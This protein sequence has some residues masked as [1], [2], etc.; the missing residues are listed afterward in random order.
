MTY[1]HLNIC[2][3]AFLRWGKQIRDRGG[4]GHH[5]LSFLL[6]LFCHPLSLNIKNYGKIVSSKLTSPPYYLLYRHLHPVHTY[7]LRIR[8][9]GQTS[10][11]RPV[12]PRHWSGTRGCGAETNFC[13]FNHFLQSQ[14]Q[15]PFQFMLP[16]MPS[17]KNIKK[18][19][20]GHKPEPL[21]ATAGNWSFAPA[22]L[23]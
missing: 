23:V 7:I 16:P 13:N 10:W 12:H 9:A 1:A 20:P 18:H 15:R 19:R 2:N 17:Q 5:N 11:H 4:Q 8:L 3:Q 22:R 21:S 6:S 14:L